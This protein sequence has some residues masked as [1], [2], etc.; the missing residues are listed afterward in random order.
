MKESILGLAVCS[1][2][3]LELLAC[4]G[5]SLIFMVNY[6]DR[7]KGFV[8]IVFSFEGSLGVVY[9]FLRKSLGVSEKHPSKGSYKAFA[10]V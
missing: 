4:E 3:G 6:K 5:E 1:P 8:G 10:R 2:L 9:V 7:F